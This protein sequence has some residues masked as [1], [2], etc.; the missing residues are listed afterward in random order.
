M[1]KCECVVRKVDKGQ[2]LKITKEYKKLMKLIGKS[3]KAGKQVEYVHTIVYPNHFDWYD[4][5]TVT[6]CN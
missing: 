6:I 2:R 5:V 3:L 1:F 4:K